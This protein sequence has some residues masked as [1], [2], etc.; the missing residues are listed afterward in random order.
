[1]P[2][3][4]PDLESFLLEKQKAQSESLPSL[5]QPLAVPLASTINT[6]DGPSFD[7]LGFVESGLAIPPDTYVAVGPNHILEAVNSAIRIWTK[8]PLVEISSVDLA[9]FF[10]V[11]FF[12]D[13]ISDPR[14]VY[15]PASDRW[16]IVVVTLESAF[17]TADWR[18]A[19]STGP[20]P[21]V[22]PFK[23]YAASFS[24]NFP[25]FP[26]IGISSDKAV[27]TGDAYTIPSLR[28]AK[29][30]G[31]EF[32]VANKKDLTDGVS[33]PADIFFGPPQ[34]LSTVQ[35]ASDPLSSTLF[36]A[37]ASPSRKSS[38]LRIW[39]VSGVPTAAPGG[40]VTGVTVTTKDL[41]ISPLA[42]P[43]NAVQQ[44]SST[45]IETNDSRLLDA[46]FRSGS[47]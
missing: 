9:T 31:T 47:L 12:T 6:L 8:S 10:Q 19:V 33:N 42:V 37:S 24:G 26:K 43:P 32:L 2:L 7:G 46:T 13:V 38:P 14:V 1:L 34:G 35:P 15:D 39:S 22:F 41:K 25:D 4:V 23:L 17:G 44:G 21:S 18:L 45:L 29:F 5:V 20:D 28:P 11:G 3:H 27:L 30:L 36:M 40:A 16:F